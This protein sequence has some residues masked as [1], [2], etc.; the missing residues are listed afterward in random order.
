MYPG[1]VTSFLLPAIVFHF[2]FLPPSF[3]LPSSLP[4]PPLAPP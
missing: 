3:S 1:P 4:L 2:S